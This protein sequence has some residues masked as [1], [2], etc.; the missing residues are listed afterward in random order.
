MRIDNIN[1]INTY[2]FSAFETTF[3][4]FL[5]LTIFLTIALDFV[6]FF[7]KTMVNMMNSIDILRKMM[8]YEKSKMKNNDLNGLKNKD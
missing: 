4:S 5:G 3:F 8:Y 2:T 1:D 7:L 6:A